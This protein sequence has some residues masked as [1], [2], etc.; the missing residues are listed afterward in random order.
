M[1][2][3]QRFGGDL[4]NYGARAVDP[5]LGDYGNPPV[6]PTA[7]T[8][9]VGAT[10]AGSFAALVNAS[11]WTAYL[12]FLLFVTV[13]LYLLLYLT[14]YGIGYFQV[15]RQAPWLISGTLPGTKSVT[16]AQH[17]YQN[18]SQFI[19]RSDDDPNGMSFTY[20][21]WMQVDAPKDNTQKVYYPVF[22]KGRLEGLAVD[23][24]AVAGDNAPG[25]Y[26]QGGS[27]DASLQIY[28]DAEDGAY[29][30]QPRV[31]L[32]HLPLR[33]WMHVVLRLQNTALDVYVNGTIAQR[34]VFAT[35]PKQNDFDLHVCPRGGFAGSIADLRY[36]P[37]ALSAFAI[38]AISLAGPNTRASM[39]A[40]QAS[41]K[42]SETDYLAS[43]W[44]EST[45]L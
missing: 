21:W 13:M 7:T 8:G 12:S 30:R 4:Y 6:A 27:Q 5:Y 37:S 28:F 11:S 9:N 44:Y 32:K 10:L 29:S 33:K 14:I 34:I 15:A 3:M 18:P 25:V 43:T 39:H 20:S 41:V 45:I 19:A 36:Y 38:H 2:T 16:I 24:S 31:V 40:P 42:G 35:V 26:V 17:P 22:F 1:D 23:G